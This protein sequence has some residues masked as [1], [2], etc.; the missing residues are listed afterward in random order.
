MLSEAVGNRPGNMAALS[1]D[2]NKISSNKMHPQFMQ[3]S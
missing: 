3:G 1:D 2:E